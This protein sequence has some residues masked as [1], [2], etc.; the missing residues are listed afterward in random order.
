[1]PV[2]DPFLQPIVWPGRPGL[3]RS[4][5]SA[6]PDRCLLAE[7][8]LGQ[9]LPLITRQNIGPFFVFAL[10]LLTFI[11]LPLAAQSFSDHHFLLSPPE[12]FPLLAR[13]NQSGARFNGSRVVSQPC[14]TPQLLRP[15]ARMTAIQ[16][17]CRRAPFRFW[18]GRAN[19]RT[20]VP[21]VSISRW[22]A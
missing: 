3:N 8:I 19:A 11:P 15:R 2:S 18:N 10:L 20:I 6:V 13:E 14:R 9:K 12:Q 22:K 21:R 5:G 16:F 7:F 1:M 4:Y 17:S